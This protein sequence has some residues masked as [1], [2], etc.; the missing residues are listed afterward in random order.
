MLKFIRA[1][2]IS[3]L[4][5][6]G[7]SGHAAGQALPS[8]PSLM[9]GQLDN[10]LHYVVYPHA[11]PPGRVIVWLH[12]H[13]GSLNESDKQR[14]LAHYLE[15]MSF[16]GSEHFAPGT[17]VPFFE[18]LGMTFGRDQNAFTNM[19]Q[20]TYQLTL[21]KTD[22]D[23]LGKGMTF[24]SD[25]VGHLSLIPK[26]IDDERQIIQEERRRGLSGRQRTGFYVTEH[27][28]PGSLYGQRITI[29]TEASINGVHEQDFRDYYGH[30]Y[31]A[32]NATLIVV[33]D[34]DPKTA[35][36]VIQDKFK[37][38]EKKPRPTPQDLHLAATDKNFGIV[39]S[40][41]ELRGEEIQ[42]VRVE[43]PHAAVTTMQQYRDDLV[44]RLGE[45]AF[46]RRLGEKVS[47]GG[48]S[49]LGGRAG[50]S[51]EPGAIHMVELSG[52]CAPGKW[53]ASMTDLTMELQRARAF[54]FSEHELERV[55]KQLVTGAERAVETEATSPSAGIMQRINGS[56]TSGE[57]VM[58]PQQRLDLLNKV[59]PTIKPEEVAKRFSAEFDFKAAA[60]V[61]VLPS[62]GN[63]PSET[64]LVEFGT[65][66]LAV[67]PTQETEAVSHATTL[68]AKLPTPGEVKEQTDHAASKV[69]SGWLSNNTRVHYRFM[70]ERKNQV[71]VHISLAG[72][73][74]LE[75]PETKGITG[76]A[77][78]A[79]GRSATQHLTSADIREIMS[80]KKVNVGGG[81]GGFGGG[82]GGGGRRG[83]GGGPG[84]GG[85][86]LALAING[87][88]E[89]LET[90]F[91]LAYL[92]LTEPKIEETAFTQYK[93]NRRQAL[94]EEGTNPN[95]VATRLIGRAPY[96]DNDF[97]HQPMTVEQLDKVT[98]AGAQAWLEKLIKESP[99]EVTIVGDLPKDKAMA[100][101]NQYIGSLPSRPR[102][103]SG[104][105]ADMRKLTRPKGPRV[106]EKTVDSPTKAATVYCGFYGP[107][108]AN[109]ADTR[110]MSMAARIL[111]MRMVKEVREEMQLVYSMGATS[112][113]GSV[114]PGFGT[115]FATAPTEPSKAPAL[116]AK[117]ESMYELFAKDGPSDE[118]VDTAKKQY[119]KDWPEAIKEPTTWLA[120][121]E[122]MDLRGTSLDDFLGGPQAYQA[123]TAKQVKDTFAKYYSKDNSIIVVVKPSGE[124]A[125]KGDGAEDGGSN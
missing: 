56:V 90:G 96:A 124:G 25:I 50:S 85:D 6:A 62:G 45:S 33:G 59:L 22:A 31:T 14:G 74:L 66:A 60:F 27:L 114:Y 79:W 20:T 28:T 82:R 67:K 47:A 70:D 81:G 1:S 49:Y 40:D 122:N 23:T 120:R 102:I 108:E 37:D 26:E 118:E 11:I 12:M 91:Q 39:T 115:F 4:S 9:T 95:Q 32:S 17:L 10:G 61:A 46:N 15:H 3:A 76:A 72:G 80:D 105:F 65:K 64:E 101:V 111:S 117:I 125:G 51:N 8:D 29:G 112:R 2:L 44:L 121:L 38:A 123:L 77:Q 94:L 48:T 63:I 73:D 57:P 16:N 107:D 86:T 30:W 75:T 7:A 35:I 92:L 24:F 88:P 110:A 68:M 52:N 104:L 18:S 119:A 55:K 84:G 58:S 83:G 116:R 93:T 36:Q 21:P 53:R 97:R 5:I 103:S 19:E 42:I 69:W 113:P 78:L 100:L 87:S 34:V 106:F 71:T 89:D 43:P 13:S 98:I 54:G 99:I 109:L 41:P